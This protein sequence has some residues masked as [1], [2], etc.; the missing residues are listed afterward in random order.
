MRKSNGFGNYKELIL[1]EIKENRKW[2]ES[3][4]E[5]INNLRVDVGGLKVKAAVA[6]GAAGLVGTGLV[7]AILAAFK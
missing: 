6:G 5:A 4:Y 7:S 1:D 2:R 3:M